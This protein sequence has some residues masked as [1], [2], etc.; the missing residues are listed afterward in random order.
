MV[1]KVD[2]APP[3]TLI[4]NLRSRPGIQRVKTV[5]VPPRDA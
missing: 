4:D 3:K 1:L 2:S 5:A